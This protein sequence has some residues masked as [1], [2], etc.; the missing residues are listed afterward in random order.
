MRA[1]ER[2]PLVA[3]GADADVER[4]TTT[5][6]TR[7]D[8]VTPSMPEASPRDGAG[9]WW[10]PRRAVTSI[11]SLALVGACALGVVGAGAGGGSV[12]SLAGLG[13]R[14]EVDE[15]STKNCANADGDMAVGTY[16]IETAKCADAATAGCLGK[17]TMCRF[18]QTHMATNRNHDW[19]L[20]PQKVC[21]EHDAFGC[22]MDGKK[23]SKREVAWS[24]LRRHVI[25]HNKMI[26]GISLGKCVGNAQDQK[27][28]RYQYKDEQCKGPLPGC[29]GGPNKCRFCN[30]KNAKKAEKGWPTCPMLVCDKYKVKSKHCEEQKKFGVPPE[31]PPKDWDGG[32]LTSKLDLDDDDDDDDDGGDDDK[33][34]VKS[35][36]HHHA[37]TDDD[38][39]SSVE[40][41]KK[42]TKDDEDED[43][44]DEIN[45]AAEDD[46]DEDDDDDDDEDDDDDK[47]DK[48]DNDEDEDEDEDEET[49]GKSAKKATEQKSS[50]SLQAGKS[51]DEDDD[52]YS[53]DEVPVENEDDDANEDEVEYKHRHSDVKLGK[54]ERDPSHINLA[55]DLD[56]L[57]FETF[58]AV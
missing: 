41:H 56:A 13:K 34:K 8:G 2:A 47:D 23:M 36:K 30:V 43:D 10:T 21:D 53:K 4:A 6:T 54:A 44:D 28:G 9:G 14:R 3:R 49:A 15:G 48:D 50:S 40:T 33:D 35:K 25:E 5:A 18:C 16:Q 52:Y 17:K 45:R 20:C 32:A 51:E 24:I 29:L 37:G 39:H 22:K 19:P 7:E 38:K 57:A 58:D 11:A 27:L 46:K 26:D 12:V 31:T 42:R 55:E 1:S